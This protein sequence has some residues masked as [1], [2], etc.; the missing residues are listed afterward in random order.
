M[1]HVTKKNQTEKKAIS[2]P[3]LKYEREQRG[4]T[5]AYVA[6][7]VDC[8]DPHMI[9][10]W[11][12]GVISPSPRYRQALC[13]LF[14]KNAEELGF[15]PRPDMLHEQ[16]L[17]QPV[18][19]H[20]TTT[21]H[22]PLF[23]S[24]ENTLSEDRF[25]LP[26]QLTSFVGRKQEIT[27]ICELL[28]QPEVR[29]LTLTGTGG[30]GKTRLGAQIVTYLAN[31]FTAG[32]LVLSL[33]ETSSP[34]LVVPTIAHKL[35]LQEIGNQPMFDLLK[36]FLKEKHLL[37]LLDNFEQVVEAAPVLTELLGC[38]PRLKLLV[39]SRTVLRVSGEY[40]FFV[41]PLALPD[42][43]HLPEKEQLTQYPAVALFLER[44][45]TVLPN[46][47]M[48]DNNAR[49]I[50]EICT[51]LDGLPL[52][53]ELAVPR[54]KLLSPQTLLVRLDH[55]L[56][57]LTHGAQ[58]APVRQ[59]TLRNTLEWS[60]RLLNPLEQRLFCCLSLFV[61]GCTLEAIEIIWATL[62][63]VQDKG[64]VLEGVASLLDKSMLQRTVQEGEEPRLLMLRTIREYGL[65]HL[66]LEGKLEQTQL[67]HARYYLT[68]A[69]EAEPA[70]KGPHLLP[71]LER[72]EQE[73][74][75][76]REAFC[77]LI[78]HGENGIS[79]RTEMALRLGKA[80]ER[81]W[82]IRG[83][84]KEGRDLL[85]RAL[86][87]NSGV[88]LSIQGNAVHTTTILADLQGDLYSVGIASIENLALF[89]ELGDAVGIARSL[90]KLGYVAQMQGEYATART[91]YEES[92]VI[93][94]RE[95]CKEILNETLFYFASMTL[96]QG[97]IGTAHTMIEECLVISRELGD[98][99]SIAATLNIMGWI[100]LLQGDAQ[101][102][103]TLE[104]ENLAICRMLRSQHGIAH[105]LNA[106]GQIT[107]L[108][109][110]LTQAAEYLEESLMIM[111]R[112]GDRWMI[113]FALEGLAGVVVAQGE[114]TWAVY[115]L[116]VATVLR[117][118]IGASISS[119]EQFARERTLATIHDRLDEQAFASAWAAGQ[120]MS[121]AQAIAARRPLMGIVNAMS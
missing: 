108:A 97:D 35:G 62:E 100:M 69:E 13:E 55:R 67:A 3:Q 68:L 6:T 57:I 103:L 12:R 32:A 30:V 70:L 107:F 118:V 72:L 36:V 74:D 116:S 46:F 85:E 75:N 43:A 29:L 39:T 15:I 27:T 77:N 59:Q 40:E 17:D 91:Y 23:S 89:R 53:I 20:S 65:E 120:T 81:F 38:C 49:V 37:L 8:P 34:D 47:T 4:W 106:L 51:H 111:M 78:A 87:H 64:Q 58:D 73:H 19:E 63:D 95:Q 25:F 44:A 94:R 26:A 50:A 61:G 82:I 5:I 113:A 18:P 24:R 45:R 110:D 31:D 56:R 102:A 80:L 112:L 90:S 93:A 99:Y 14:G 52:A 98:Q 48:N 86:K 109:G 1:Y 54:L 71:W 11:E 41:S 105:A 96:F 10:R 121:P 22:S 115:L 66:S 76:L 114:A 119:L 84:V 33:V 21:Q 83:Y 28:R 16:A 92:L 101:V 104:E 7:Q 2:K 117:T 88:S 9:G 79:M 60:Y 42:L